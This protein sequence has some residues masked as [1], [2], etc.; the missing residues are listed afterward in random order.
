MYPMA[1]D[2]SLPVVE[3]PTPQTV[4]SAEPIRPQQPPTPRPSAPAPPS[5]PSDE[6]SVH[7]APHYI[8]TSP[9]VPPA[10]ASS[11]LS[12]ETLVAPR[13][14]DY[15]A[16]AMSGPHHQPA[17]FDSEQASCPPLPI[18]FIRE[19]Q[20]GPIYQAS[21]ERRCFYCGQGGHWNSECHA[22]HTRCLAA[23]RCVV[24]TKHAHFVQACQYG[25]RTRGGN[26]SK[27]KRRRADPPYP[28]IADP[29]TPIPGS[30]MEVEATPAEADILSAATPEGSLLFSPVTNPPALAE[31][32]FWDQIPLETL[33]FQSQS[34]PTATPQ[35]PMDFASTQDPALICTCPSGGDGWGNDDWG[36]PFRY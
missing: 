2:A 10:S 30:S 15:T 13:R 21:L 14:P 22:P 28:T 18:Q 26:V 36:T 33:T 12:G 5:T 17:P 6:G 27:R 7:L 29:G 1:P 23:S 16:G 32:T 31:P 35:P 19:G 3:E 11:R 25:G 9:S 24:P 20:E 34:S 4:E 8:P